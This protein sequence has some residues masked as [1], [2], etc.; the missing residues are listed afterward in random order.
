MATSKKKK[1]AEED[2]ISVD[3]DRRTKMNAIK[4][5][6]LN[7]IFWKKTKNKKNHED[8]PCNVSL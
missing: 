1:N 7:K 5:C 2:K 8:Y 4:Q 3:I 6:R